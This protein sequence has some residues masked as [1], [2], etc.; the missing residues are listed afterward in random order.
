[1]VF[2]TELFANYVNNELL[3]TLLR[4]FNSYPYPEKNTIRLSN[5]YFSDEESEAKRS[6]HLF[7]NPWQ[8]KDAHEFP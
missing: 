6:K 7:Y 2:F 1:M 4:I 8:L 3:Q 5:Y